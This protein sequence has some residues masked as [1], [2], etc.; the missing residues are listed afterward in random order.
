MKT[1]DMNR[2]AIYFTGSVAALTLL[3]S[4]L[5]AQAFRGPGPG[6]D[7]AVID[8]DKDGQITQAEMDAYKAQRAAELDGD[9][10]G[11]ISADEMAAGMMARM[12]ERMTTMARHRL[13]DQDK[14]GD[15]K[16]SLAEMAEGPG[17]GQLFSRADA[18]GDGALTEDEIAAVRARMEEGMKDGGGK[19]RGGDRH[20]KGG[21]GGMGGPFWLF[22]DATDAPTE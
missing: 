18:N 15:G 9:K 6:F 19:H 5:P 3:M 22:D 13:V 11:F 17:E 20:G 12:A 1:K 7:F 4:V 2:P 14:D 16:V 21:M 8:A 10:D